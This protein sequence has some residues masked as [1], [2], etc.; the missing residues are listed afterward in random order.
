MYVKATYRTVH[1]RIKQCPQVQVEARVI[2][3]AV[4]LAPANVLF[5]EY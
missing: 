1:D 2:S 4:E 3:E 5:I